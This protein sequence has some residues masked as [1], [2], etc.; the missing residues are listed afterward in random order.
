MAKRKSVKKV[1][2]VK[3]AAP[4]A[5]KNNERLNMLLLLLGFSIVFLLAVMMTKAGI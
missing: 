4:K 1:K 2:S 5:A 3:R